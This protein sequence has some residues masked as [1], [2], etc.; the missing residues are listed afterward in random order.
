MTKMIT[1]LMKSS[2]LIALCTSALLSA[3]CNSDDGADADVEIKIAKPVT[4]S[5][6]GGTAKAQIK[7]LSEAG[8]HAISTTCYGKYG[9]A[10]IDG[11]LTD[12]ID[13]RPAVPTILYVH[14][15]SS[16]DI[17]KAESLGFKRDYAAQEYAHETPCE[18]PAE[19]PANI[20]PG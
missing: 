11:P 2:A 19:I 12:P 9:K 10:P 1:Y 4:G 7:T 18:T 13:S 20:V 15:I 5:D 6:I 14:V 3:G 8:V 16:R 17:D